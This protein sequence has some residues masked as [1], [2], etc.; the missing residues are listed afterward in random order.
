MLADE[1]LPDV[2]RTVYVCS[3][4]NDILRQGWGGT[5][6]ET[7]CG[8]VATCR[9]NALRR[10]SSRTPFCDKEQWFEQD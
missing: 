5:S 3:E 2:L 10:N 8:G 7:S 1:A 9:R 4:L 6:G